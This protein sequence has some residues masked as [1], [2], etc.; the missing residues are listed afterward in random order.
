MK[1]KTRMYKDVK[2]FL[3]INGLQ[4][5]T[6]LFNVITRYEKGHWRV[7]DAD[8]AGFNL[9]NK[10]RRIKPFRVSEA[11]STRWTNKSEHLMDTF[12]VA[13]FDSQSCDDLVLVRDVLNTVEEIKDEFPNSQVVL[14]D[15]YNVHEEAKGL[16]RYL[17]RI[18]QYN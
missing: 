8:P 5:V 9:L 10:I 14:N 6:I 16:S 2:D 11:N 4:S 17:H 12:Y 1:R 18:R 7:S 13:R 3:E 15:Y